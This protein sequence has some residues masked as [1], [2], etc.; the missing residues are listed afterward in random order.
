MNY[1]II[2]IPVF[3]LLC[4]VGKAQDNINAID[5]YF[6]EYV[7]DELF[8]VVY[9][10]PRLFQLVG[11]IGSEE[12]DLND[13]EADAFIDMASDLRGLRILSTS[14]K[15][16]SY[17]NEFRSKVDTRVY[18][19][20]VTIREKNGGRLEFFLR[21]NAAGDIEELLFFSVG[22]ESFTL[23]SFVG[24]LNLDKIIRLAEEIDK[25]KE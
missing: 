14:T 15:P 2:F 19:T 13:K 1:K 11:K 18:E 8:S 16:Q 25:N 20:L 23:M 10:S 6:Q 5:E 9:I 24:P 22:E 7:E 17:F 21:E 4:F 3:I 12:L